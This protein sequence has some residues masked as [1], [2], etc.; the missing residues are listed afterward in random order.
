MEALAGQIARE[1]AGLS[2]DLRV[3]PLFCTLIPRPV[4]QALG[5]LDEN[6]TVGMFEDDD[7]SLR[8]RRAGY[9]V[10]T[11]EDCFV[12]HF[13]RGSFSQLDPRESERI[14]ETN[15][16]RFEKKWGE[17]WQPHRYRPDVRPVHRERRFSPAEFCAPP[18]KTAQ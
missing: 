6:F 18:V 9:R 10:V 4:W 5:E 2:I 8:A 14:F 15:R 3:A 7:Y 16:E 13:G 1:R 12:H 11:A 17:P